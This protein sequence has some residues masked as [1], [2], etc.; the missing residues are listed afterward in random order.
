MPNLFVTVIVPCFNAEKFLRKTIDSVIAQTYP[1]IN[2]I[3]INDGSSDN[4]LE[5]L[6][7]YGNITTIHH[8]NIENKG[9]AA[10]IN[11]GIKNSSSELLAFID[12]DD[13]WDKN[14][15]KEQVDVFRKHDDVGLCYVNGYV[16]SEGCPFLYCLLPEDFIEDNVVGKILLNC[17]VRTPSMVMVKR[18]IFDKT[19]ATPGRPQVSR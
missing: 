19:A 12:A 7:E 17:Y 14:K 4:T 1:H 16:F 6:K 2:I 13:I 10:S 5:I 8:R 9:Q 18:N 15:I 11:L 3:A